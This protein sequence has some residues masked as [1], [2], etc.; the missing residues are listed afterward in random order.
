MI[1]SA[2]EMRRA[3]SRI[4]ISFVVAVAVVMIGAVAIAKIISLMRGPHE[5]A[6]DLEAAI[7]GYWPLILL[8]I[9]L[10]TFGLSTIRVGRVR[11]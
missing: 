7:G 1:L 10:L 4:L 8:A 3:I 11:A 2:V 9:A 5:A 6:A